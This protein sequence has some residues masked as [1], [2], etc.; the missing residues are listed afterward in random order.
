MCK[1]I[2]QNYFINI[3]QQHLTND[4][5]TLTLYANICIYSDKILRYYKFG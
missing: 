5:Q 2:A 1:L 3:K 4:T